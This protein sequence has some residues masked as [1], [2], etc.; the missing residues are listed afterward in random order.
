MSILINILSTFNSK[1]LT[2][3]EKRTKAFNQTV[4]SLGVTMAAT[5]GARRI[6]DFA[7]QSIKAFA[8]EDKAIRALSLNL[9]SLGL[10]YDVTPIEDYIDKLQRATGQRHSKP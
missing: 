4:K 8:E 7:K 10:A 5:F 2:A 3:A 9:K 1:G 6:L